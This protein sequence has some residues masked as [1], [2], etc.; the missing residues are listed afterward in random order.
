MCSF[1]S[2][3]LVQIW[4]INVSTHVF[5]CWAVQWCCCLRLCQY[6]KHDI[7]M[8]AVIS[9][10]MPVFMSVLISVIPWC[11]VSMPVLYC[12]FIARMSVCLGFCCVRQVSVSITVLSWSGEC[13][14]LCCVVSSS[15]AFMSVLMS[16]LDVCLCHF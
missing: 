16:C 4:L 15:A 12:L 13:G 7:F 2:S 5:M 3:D 11:V 6:D 9:R 1:V 14:C 10:F 8:S